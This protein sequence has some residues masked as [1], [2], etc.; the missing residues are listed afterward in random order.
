MSNSE[1]NNTEAAI[2]AGRELANVTNRLADSV[3]DTGFKIPV[4]LKTTA[5]GGAE[6][7]VLRD[8]IA[9]HERIAVGPRRRQ[10]TVKLTEEDS[11]IAHVLR[12]GSEHTVIYA[13]TQLLGFTAVLDEHPAGPDEDATRWRE[14]RATYACPRS[15][16]WITW[17]ALDGKAMKQTDFADFIEGRL[18]DLV[19]SGDMPKPLEVLGMARKLHI[20]TDG[21][22]QRE[23]DP[24][25]G[26][27]ILISK[28]ETKP[29]STI[30]PR[31]FMIA[32][33]VF[34]GG[35]RYSVECR[36]RLVVGEG[37][38][39]LSYTMHRRKEIE[40]DAFNAVRLKVSETT[41]RLILAGTP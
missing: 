7:V 5:C 9:E 35:V 20:K 28:S 4:A 30:I 11:F 1:Q 15:Q 12:W 22:Y 34:E 21:T 26:D 32:V 8:V 6:V 19:S 18:E 2:N 29:G 13:D 37:G 41:K 33:P 31:A 3:G 38:P 17:T 23:I 36:V 16:E 10:N 14:S 27:Y 39:T 25:S 40:R 24:T